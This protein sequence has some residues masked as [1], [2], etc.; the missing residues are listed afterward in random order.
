MF[1]PLVSEEEVE[2]DFTWREEI[3]GGVGALGK[4]RQTL[5]CP[6]GGNRDGPADAVW[7]NAYVHDGAGAHR[8]RRR[9]AVDSLGLAP[10]DRRDR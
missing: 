3:L 7:R 5:R 10:D 4:L 1:Q 8:D 2:V 6:T 9:P